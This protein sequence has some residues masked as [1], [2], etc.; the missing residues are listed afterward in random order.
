MGNRQQLLRILKDML[1]AP[2]ENELEAI[3]NRAADRLIFLIAISRAIT[4]FNQ[5]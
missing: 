5:S 4:I 2:S 1:Y 3:F